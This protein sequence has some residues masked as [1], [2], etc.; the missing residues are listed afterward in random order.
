MSQGDDTVAKRFNI[1]IIS[2]PLMNEKIRVRTWVE[3]GSE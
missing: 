3:V 1:F 2:E